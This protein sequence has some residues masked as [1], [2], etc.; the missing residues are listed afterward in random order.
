MNE[1]CLPNARCEE[2]NIRIPFAM[3]QMKQK[4]D[5]PISFDSGST[6]Q[7]VENTKHLN[8]PGLWVDT[9][10]QHLNITSPTDCAAR[11]CFMFVPRKVRTCDFVCFYTPHHH[12]TPTRHHLADHAADRRWT[13]LEIGFAFADYAGRFLQMCRQDGVHP[14]RILKGSFCICWRSALCSATARFAGQDATPLWVFP[15]GRFRRRHS[16]AFF[17]GA[18]HGQL[19]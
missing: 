6:T 16:F 14:S 15:A 9:Q 2:E 10:G 5:K 4:D 18:S 19:L 3:S 17:G 11:P 1:H 8:C 7:H 13:F 12:V